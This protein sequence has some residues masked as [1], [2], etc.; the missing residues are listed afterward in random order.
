MKRYLL[1][2]GLTALLAPAVQ[3][4]QADQIKASHAWIRLLP[5]DLPAGGY[6]TL[7]N[8]G[9]SAATLVSVHSA[10]YAS[11]ML[12]Q[13][14]TDPAGNSDMHMLDRLI[15][16]AHGQ[17]SLAPAGYHLMLQQATHALK[18]GDT[19]DITLDFADGSHQRVPFQVRPANA[20]D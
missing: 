4:T 7:D 19:V 8:Q 12:H 18:P 5:A 10:A 6:V 13:S 16:P 20:T 2:L 1:W 3:A 14:T 17:V 15:V 11:A 9:S